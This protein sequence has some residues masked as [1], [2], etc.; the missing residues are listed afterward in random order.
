MSKLV[1]VDRYLLNNIFTPIAQAV[2]S[3]G[4]KSGLMRV[5]ASVNEIADEIRA[6]PGDCLKELLSDTLYSYENS[7]AKEIPQSLFRDKTYLGRVNFS[8]VT[9]INQYAFAG[10]TGLKSVSFPAL[11]SIDGNYAFQNCT[12]LPEFITGEAFDSKLPSSAFNGCA[13]L[14]R[15]DFYH[16]NLTTGITANALKCTALETLI[17]RN[18]DGVPKLVSSGLSGATK[19]VNGTG[20]IYVPAEMVEAYKAA[21]NWS[22][23]ADQ[24]RAIEDYP[25]I[26]GGA[27]E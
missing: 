20:Y 7:T 19:I 9:T 26:T 18:T 13:K 24:I 4:G 11:K 3:K 16:I 5:S 1:A 22:T 2:R 17:I 14:A 15:A 21:T 27:E 25:E 6:L 23:Y 8:A 10:C 12:A